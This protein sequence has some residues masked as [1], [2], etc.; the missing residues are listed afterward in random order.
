MLDLKHDFQYF[1]SDK[2]SFAF[3]LYGRYNTITPGQVDFSENSD[4]KSY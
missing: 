2:S 3:G 1:I 4:F